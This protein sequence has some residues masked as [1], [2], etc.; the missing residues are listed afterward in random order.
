MPYNIIDQNFET[1]GWIKKLKKM[2]IKIHVRSIFLRF[3]LLNYNNIPK[4][5]L[6]YKNYL[7]L[8]QEITSNKISRVEACLNFVLNK[9]IF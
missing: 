2:N 3:T 9:K 6:K 8:D 5:F 4:K 1:S 7:K